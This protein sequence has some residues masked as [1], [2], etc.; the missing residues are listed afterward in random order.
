MKK[1]KIF[2][3]FLLCLMVALAIGREFHCAPKISKTLKTLAQDERE[4]LEW[5]FQDLNFSGAA[6]VLFG[7]KPMSICLFIEHKLSQK[8]PLG[9]VIDLSSRLCLPNVRI[10]K[11]LEV[12][13]K[14]NHLFTSSKFLLLEN[15]K[16]DLITIVTIHKQNFLKKVEENID[17]FKAVLGAHMTPAMLLKQCLS[18]DNIIENVLKNNDALL[19]TLLGYGRHNAELFSRRGEIEEGKEFRKIPLTNKSLTPSDGFSTVEEE[20][21][22]IKGVLRG[23]NQFYGCDWNPLCLPLPGFIV[24]PNHPETQQLKNEYKKQYKKIINF[25]RKKDFLEVTLKQFCGC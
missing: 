19:G 1:R 22:S 21:H 17:L 12:W 23:V 24:D 9:T 20:Y 14:Y 18:S 10:N 8:D 2:G 15:R 6:Y 7:N 13:K 4:S 5:F 25:Y 16:Q 11:G 3:F